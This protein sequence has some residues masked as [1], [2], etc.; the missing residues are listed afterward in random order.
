MRRKYDRQN[1]IISRPREL[2]APLLGP[3]SSAFASPEHTHQ[4]SAHF[5]RALYPAPR[6]GRPTVLIA[7]LQADPTT[8]VLHTLG[9]HYRSAF[10]A[11]PIAL[12]QPSQ[13]P[14]YIFD[15]RTP[16]PRRPTASARDGKAAV[17]VRRSRGVGS[18]S[19]SRVLGRGAPDVSMTGRLE[20][21]ARA[22]TSTC[23]WVLVRG[24]DRCEG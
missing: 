22:L 12:D 10:P 7:R 24:S 13:L 14:Q 16:A 4:S 9:E 17:C 21:G 23:L 3:S 5:R 6:R 18:R 1:P 19:R 20:V 2:N 11:P 15:G 8:S